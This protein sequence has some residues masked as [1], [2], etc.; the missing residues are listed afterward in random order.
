MDRVRSGNLVTLGREGGRD[1][2]KAMLFFFLFFLSK[3]VGLFFCW[4][5]FFWAE[6]Q[7]GR[8]FC[9]GVQKIVGSS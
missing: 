1:A 8:E 7:N 6:I 2:G 3:E 9:T 5:I 4:E